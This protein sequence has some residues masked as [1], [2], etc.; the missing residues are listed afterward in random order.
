MKRIGSGNGT[1]A[2]AIKL[3][4]KGVGGILAAQWSM[5]CRRKH[6]LTRRY[7]FKIP[8]PRVRD[9]VLSLTGGTP[10]TNN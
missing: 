1:S 9:Y 2:A 8:S 6:S 5:V 3:A 10:T 7:M 4:S